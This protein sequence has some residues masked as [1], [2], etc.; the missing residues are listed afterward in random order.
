[1]NQTI[2]F[3][4]SQISLL[5]ADID[6][7]LVNREKILTNR[8][9][10]AV[11]NLKQA[12]IIFTITSGRP[13]L[14]MKMIVDALNLTAPMAGFNGAVFFNSDLSIIDQNVL[15]QAIAKQVIEIIIA[16]RLDVWV[17]Q[18][19]DWFVPERH[20]SHVD[21]EEK[22]VKFSPTVVSNFDGLLN[23]V[24]KIVGVSDDLEAVARCEVDMQREF[25]GQICCQIGASS[26]NGE[27]VSAARSQP[28]YLDVT[29]PRANKGAV[30]QRLAELLAIP[31]QEIATIGDM[32]N[33]VPMFEQSGLSIAMGNAS[34]Q[35]QHQAKY[36]TTSYEEEGFANAVERF[37]L[38]NN[39][40]KSV[41]DEDSRES[42]VSGQI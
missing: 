1:M 23:N 37:I 24:A 40:S 29:Y 11:Q 18:G 25:S 4:P 15:T 30:V 9:Y 41:L 22:T 12:G 16:H 31:A 3:K 33:D 42:T 8:T 36:V 27:Q 39:R 10:T 13:P 14:G 6:G 28:Y 19:K 26:G 7:T 34:V 32:P 2:Q 35:V 17:Y 21:R 38:G 20:G 5:V